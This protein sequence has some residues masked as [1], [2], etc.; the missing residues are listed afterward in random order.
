[1]QYENF[2]PYVSRK[3]CFKNE[4][5]I[6][7]CLIKLHYPQVYTHLKSLS[8]PLEYYFYEPFSTFYSSSILS[9]DLIL[10]MWDMI[11]L[12]LSTNDITHRK[13]SLWYLLALPLYMIKM[14]EDMIV[15][16]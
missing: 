8:V 11:I 10:R 1:M 4:M 7:N 16:S 3:V 9:S 14:N 6:L 5:V 13:R 15:R 12:N 2:S